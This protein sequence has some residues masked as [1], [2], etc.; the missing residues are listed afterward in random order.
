M[1]KILNPLFVLVIAG[2]LLQACQS[3]EQK[4]LKKIKMLEAE[5][6]GDASGMIDRE[7]ALALVNA[8]V[9]FAT[10]NPSHDKSAE[11]LFRA[12]DISM[13]TAYPERAIELYSRVHRDYPDYE[14]NPESLFLIAFIFDNKLENLQKAEQTYKQF[15]ELYPDH[16]LADD[17]EILLEHLGKSPDEMVREF[18]EKMKMQEAL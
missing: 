5:V 14:K 7:K 6:Y 18:E 10:E 13:N 17:A 4:Q 8:Y 1:R 2:V 11:Y 15:R 12:G 16:G 3:P 9:D